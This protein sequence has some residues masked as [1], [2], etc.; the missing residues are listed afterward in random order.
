MVSL[1]DGEDPHFRKAFFDPYHCPSD[2]DRPCERVCPTHAIYAPLVPPAEPVAG[3][4]E[5]LCYG[6]GRCV[7]VC[8]YD[9]IATTSRQATPD[10]LIPELIAAGIDAIELHT[11]IGREGA[12]RQLWTAIAPQLPHLKLVAVSCHDDHLDPARYVDYL[13]SLAAIV[14]PDL[15]QHPD[16]ALVWQTDGRPMSGDLG[17]GSTRAA[18]AL[19]QR[20]AAAG[21]PGFVQ[22]AGGTND[23]T[24][25]K[26]QSM[27]LFPT[28]AG[29]A[30]G[31]AAR[32]RLQPLLDQLALRE[33]IS[34][35]VLPIESQPDLWATAVAAARSLIAPLKETRAA[36]NAEPHQTEPINARSANARSVNVA[37]VNTR[38][39]NAGSAHPD[40][41]HPDSAHP[42][43]AHP[44]SA[45]PDSAHPDSAHP[46]S[47]YPDSAHPD[48]AHPESA[49]PGWVISGD[50]ASW[51]A[52]APR[53]P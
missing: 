30:Y 53:P 21:L 36:A 41:A 8:P 25:P 35:Q 45:Y 34:G 38:P 6:C 37:S 20:V 9:R 3:V 28:I 19:G 24:V 32:S 39:T 48:S 44:E 47:A 1:N 17:A 15:A 16:C 46:E 5:A 40:S 14:T 50:A 49:Q 31:G 51:S 7:T 52:P 33:A 10:R 22:L 26:L 43:S 23:R 18:I 27:G 11:Q 12:F 4:S 13:R 29:V 2:C 42:D